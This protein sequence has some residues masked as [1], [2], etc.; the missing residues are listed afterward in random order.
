MNEAFVY[1][2]GD[3][4]VIRIGYSNDIVK[5][6]NNH[7]KYG[8]RLLAILPATEAEENKLHDHFRPHLITDRDKSTYPLGVVA[9]YVERLLH[10]QYAAPSLDEA[11]QWSQPD[12]QLWRPEKIEQPLWE[13]NQG[14]L[15]VTEG[16]K[17]DVRDTYE[18]PPEIIDL[19]RRALGGSID[20]DP[21]SNA[22]ANRN[23][24]ATCFYTEKQNG[25]TKP[26]FGRVFLNPP[27][28][29]SKEPGAALF[30]AKLVNEI[31]CGN[32]TEA[33]TVLNLQSMPTLWFPVVW[34]N[35]TAHGVWKRR[36]DFIRPR[37]ATGSKPF[38]SSKNGTIF[39]YFGPH[40]DRFLKEF[41]HGAMVWK[42]G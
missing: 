6:L 11:W 19:S 42:C 26:W 24:R 13:G 40:P 30:T 34:N 1:F 33:I 28:G 37:T 22:V 21:C 4:N 3:Q 10:W 15:F 14:S 5:R 16:M 20:T 29:G 25:L 17:A 27:Y 36:I 12:F 9:P 23:V 2:C 32:V 7:S 35:A 39:S 41:I 18:T 8:L 31:N 38:S